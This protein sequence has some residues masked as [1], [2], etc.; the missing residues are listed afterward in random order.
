MQTTMAEASLR[1]IRIAEEDCALL[2]VWANDPETRRF[3]IRT[4]PISWHTHTAWFARKRSDLNCRHYLAINDE[5]RPIGQIRFDVNEGAAEVSITIDR[6]QR[7]R[8]YAVL[9]I[10]QGVKTLFQDTAFPALQ[11]V[12]AFIKPDNLPSQRAFERAGFRCLGLQTKR[13]AEFVLLCPAPFKTLA[14][15]NSRQLFFA[16]LPD[17]V[18]LIFRQLLPDEAI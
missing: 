16:N 6:K 11:T 4:E 1:L 5:E 17:D 13:G 14:V 18:T 10:A 7:G 15:P 3:S 9:L 2:Y 12:V 8:G